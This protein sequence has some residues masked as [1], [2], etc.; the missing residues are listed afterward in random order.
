M[1]EIPTR[2]LETSRYSKIFDNT[3]KAIEAGQLKYFKM[4]M[5]FI[6]NICSEIKLG[7]LC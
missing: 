3:I 5:Q 7:K 4:V 6:K 2:N 1:I